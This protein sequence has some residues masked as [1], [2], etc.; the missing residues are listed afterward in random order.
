LIDFRRQHSSGPSDPEEV[1]VLEVERTD[2]IEDV[3][4]M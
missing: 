2:P 3:Q 1:I 4:A